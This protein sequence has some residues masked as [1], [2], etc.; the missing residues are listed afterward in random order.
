M[1][2]LSWLL[3]LFVGLKLCGV[4]GWGWLWVLSPFWAPLLLACLFFVFSAYLKRRA[5]RRTWG[6]MSLEQKARE[7]KADASAT[8]AQAAR[9]ICSGAGRA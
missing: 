4:I 8:F 1:G 9:L 2:V 7:S 3:L 5:W 6:V